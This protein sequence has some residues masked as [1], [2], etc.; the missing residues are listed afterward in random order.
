MNN[1]QNNSKPIT[2]PGAIIIAGALIAISLVWIKQ[3][4]ATT[5]QKAAANNLQQTGEINIR[6]VTAD[7][8]ILGNPNA[9]IKIVEYS[10]P[11]C[12]FCKIF[13]TTMHQVMETY[14]STGKVAWVYRHFPI[15]KPGANGQ[16]LHPNAGYEAQAF[17][18]AASIG[19]N[20]TFWTFEK[21]FYEVTPSVTPQTPSGLDRKEIPLIAKSVGIDE[22]SFIN[23]LSNGKFKSK[24]EDDYVDGL[25][26]GINGTPYSIIITSSGSKIP[27]SGA[28]PYATIK[29]AL[30]ALITETK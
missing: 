19:G 4:V 2:I 22:T 8:H 7:D 21:K 15:D 28:Q 5:S 3:P 11:S 12:P 18:C 23:C 25:N 20:T 24:V 27:I 29:T 14:G 17:E 13:D 10:D 30:D 9:P 6:P 26:A 1:E 16:I